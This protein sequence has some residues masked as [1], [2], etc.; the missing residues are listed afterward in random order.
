M[1]FDPVTFGHMAS[2]L[3]PNNSTLLCCICNAI[4][5]Y[6]NDILSRL[7]YDLYISDLQINVTL[8]LPRKT[9]ILIYDLEVT[10]LFNDIKTRRLPAKCY[11]PRM[12][13][14]AHF[15]S[16][17]AQDMRAPTVSLITARHSTSI[18]CYQ[19]ATHV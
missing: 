5:K 15:L 9:T 16:L 10:L 7:T 11:V 1:T 3:I 14:T 4:T 2:C 19:Q 8:I 17:W 12:R 13:P 18:S 6:L